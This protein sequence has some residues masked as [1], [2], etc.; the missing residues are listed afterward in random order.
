M[1]FALQFNFP[2]SSVLKLCMIFLFFHW[3]SMIF[4]HAYLTKLSLKLIHILTFP[5][6]NY[7]GL[8]T[9]NLITLLQGFICYKVIILCRKGFP[10]FSK[11]ENFLFSRFLK[12]NLINLL[13]VKSQF[14]T[15]IYCI[16]ILKRYHNTLRLL[17]Q[18]FLSCNGAYKKS[19]LQVWLSFLCWWL[20][21]S[22]WGFSYLVFVLV[23]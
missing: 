21:S 17:F 1:L 13:G 12:F 7:K 15:Y 2:L 6:N 5:P 16:L 22:I 14:L 18:Y 19:L 9:Q 3:L 4:Y 10:T 20:A 23:F 11:L 8:R